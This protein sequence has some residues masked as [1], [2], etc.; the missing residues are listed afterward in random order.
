MGVALLSASIWETSFRTLK[1]QFPSSWFNSSSL[2]L[3]F[4]AICLTYLTGLF[5]FMW[6]LM[7]AHGEKWYEYCLISRK[8][9]LLWIFQR[10]IIFSWITYWLQMSLNS[11]SGSPKI[12][13]ELTWMKF[14]LRTTNNK[15]S[16]LLLIPFMA[17][18]WQER[19]FLYLYLTCH[20]IFIHEKCSHHQ[21]SDVLYL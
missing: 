10:N 1:Y 14:A 13:N 15:V 12:Q 16:T 4:V 21:S 3:R 7:I 8:V 11:A 2:W 9:E 6:N 5:A 20:Q 18:N 17:L 19:Q